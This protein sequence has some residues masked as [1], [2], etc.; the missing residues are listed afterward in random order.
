[1]TRPTTFHEKNKDSVTLNENDL[2]AATNG[3]LDKI[4]TGT[5]ASDT[6]SILAIIPSLGRGN[7]RQQNGYIICLP[8]FAQKILCISSRKK[9][10]IVLTTMGE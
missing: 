6:E 7:E 10:N 4:C 9:T 8:L 2:C 5:G 1:M 3:F